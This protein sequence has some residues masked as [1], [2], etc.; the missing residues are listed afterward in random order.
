[1]DESCTG[2]GK[3]ID[4]GE[5]PYFIITI[6]T[7]AD[8]LWEHKLGKVTTENV[9]FLLRFQKLCELYHLRPTYL[10]TYEMV[11]HPDFVEFGHDIIKRNAGEIGMHLHAWNSPPII[12]LTNNDDFYQPYLIEYPAK[13]IR[14]KIKVMTDLLEDTFQVK[15]LS[16]RAGRW[17]FNAEYAS[18]LIDQGYLVD[19]SVTPYVSWRALPGD[20]SREG[21]TDY[22]AFPNY[23]YFVSL[24]D[25]RSRGNSPLLEVPMTIIPKRWGGL[26]RFAPSWTMNTYYLRQAIKHFAPVHWLRPNGRNLDSLLWIL[27]Q[28]QEERRD[29]VEFMLHSSELM[30]GSSPAFPT[31][32]TIETLYQHLNV[33]FE[34][35]G[36]H[37]IGATLSEYANEYRKQAERI[38]WT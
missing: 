23:P 9:H 38:G 21:G 19:C 37:F 22:R 24:S 36:E 34:A 6:D 14:E 5:R 27:Q 12:S 31:Q 11:K 2:D 17:S 29:Y 26:W 20:P 35:A 3:K 28:A 32:V 16:H 1:M 25:I 13:I 15:M 33:L 8:N 4:I 18:C 30:P 7:E 10:T